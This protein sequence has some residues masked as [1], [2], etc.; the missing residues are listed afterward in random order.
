MSIYGQDFEID[1]Q[2]AAIRAA[3]V[4]VVSFGGGGGEFQQ[5]CRLLM[6]MLVYI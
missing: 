2:G 6:R 5:T 3:V 1:E 4:A